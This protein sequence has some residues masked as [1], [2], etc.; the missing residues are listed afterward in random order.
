MRRKPAHPDTEGIEDHGG[1]ENGEH[2]R[3]AAKVIIKFHRIDTVCGLTAARTEEARPV[4]KTLR[5]VP[6]SDVTY[7]GYAWMS[8]KAIERPV[9]LLASVEFSVTSDRPTFS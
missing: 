4:A 1:D 2:Q 3:P 9:F 5:L 8:N 7:D 6:A